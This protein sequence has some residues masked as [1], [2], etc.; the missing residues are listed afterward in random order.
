M[1]Q[2]SDSLWQRDK[3]QQLFQLGRLAVR[4]GR[5]A[6]AR[7]LLERAVELDR[8]HSDAWLWPCW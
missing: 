5:R 4:E 3:G 7:D 6:E 2:D 8:E 1:S